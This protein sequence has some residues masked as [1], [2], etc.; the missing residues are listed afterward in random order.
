METS[1]GFGGSKVTAH[2]FNSEDVDLFDP[3]IVEKSIISGRTIAFRPISENTAG[4]FQFQLE[5]QGND[6]Y[7][8]LNSI[9]LAGEV[10]L[11]EN[12]TTALTATDDVSIVNMF[13]NSLFRA[14]EIEIN[15]T[16]VTDLTS[17]TAH[18]QGYIQT[19]LSYNESAQKTHLKAQL[20]E[21]DT[22]TLYDAIGVT[23][24]TE[25]GRKSEIDYKKT[26]RGYVRRSGYCTESK[27]FDF[28]IP[29][30]SDL[31]QS[32]RLLHSSASLTIR[33][34]R[35]NDAFSLLNNTAKNIQIKLSNL[36]LYAHY[37][38]VSDSLAK[39]H[40]AKLKKTPAL[41]PITRTIL[42]EYVIEGG[43]KH[44][45]ISNLFTGKLPKSIIVGFVE[46]EAASGHIKKNPFN[47][48]HFNMNECYIRRNG[49]MMPGEPLSPDFA[50]NLCTREYMEFM[51]NI[52][53]DSNEDHG[54]AITPEQFLGGSHFA[55]FDLTG[56]KCNMLHNHG[57]VDGNIDFHVQFKNALASNVR[58]IVYASTDAQIEL[59]DGGEA[60]VN[61]F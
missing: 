16:L 22:P 45:Y 43:Q 10:Q 24:Q 23:N 19:M 61:I 32:D 17:F 12:G 51:S 13:P 46:D 38:K 14:H 53:I 28:Y 29:V 47:F 11:L 33:L 6:Q 40:A 9:K 50:N 39:E 55:A 5:P 52:G 25:A 56:H 58:I 30:G 48:K 57:T 41:Y 4:P 44:K 26:N 3:S 20:F 2:S 18:Y 1:K 8:Q 37:V 34:L 60:S 49:E 21:L 59:K 42:K 27:K 31:L 15:K 7:L 54:N 36:K 35:E